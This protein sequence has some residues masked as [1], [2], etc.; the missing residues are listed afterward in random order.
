MDHSLDVLS[1]SFLVPDPP[2][3]GSMHVMDSIRGEGNSTFAPASITLPSPLPSPLKVLSVTLTSLTPFAQ[4]IASISAIASSTQALAPP[5]TK[6][7]SD[8]S[9]V[10]ILCSS[11][12]REFQL[13]LIASPGTEK[14]IQSRKQSAFKRCG[15]AAIREF[16]KNEQRPILLIP[17][18]RESDIIS[19]TRDN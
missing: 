9:I 11:Q 16:C 15:V 12:S 8:S 2:V 14:R 5:E 19:V 3:C 6:S 18:Y 13:V 4:S 10:L 17:L 7:N 1:S